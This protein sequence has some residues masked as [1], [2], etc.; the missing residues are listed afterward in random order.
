MFLR[1][2]K[3]VLKRK[4]TFDEVKVYEKSRKE[5]YGFWFFG[6]CFCFKLVERDV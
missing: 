6:N 2:F 1:E 4:G 5:T 3:F